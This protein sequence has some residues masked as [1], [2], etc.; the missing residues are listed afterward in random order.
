MLAMSGVQ[1]PC[2]VRA[3]RRS[4]TSPCV[5]QLV[6]PKRLLKL[7]L[8][9]KSACQRSRCVSQMARL[10]ARPLP[11]GLTGGRF[12][13]V[14]RK[15]S[16]GTSLGRSRTATDADM[17]SAPCSSQSFATRRNDPALLSG[18]K[19]KLEGEAEV[20]GEATP[21]RQKTSPSWDRAPCGSIFGGRLNTAGGLARERVHRLRGAD[22]NAHRG[23]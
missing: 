22:V 14:A 4:S 16:M 7:A 15:A 5:T 19:R 13:S 23:C 3:V 2:E 21:G 1:S 6:Q 12:G 11:N 18:S 8:G 9:L 10:R 20:P 17:C